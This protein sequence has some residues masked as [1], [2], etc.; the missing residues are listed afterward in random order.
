MDEWFFG[1]AFTTAMFTV[2]FIAVIWI[3]IGREERLRKERD[4]ALAANERIAPMLSNVEEKLVNHIHNLDQF[5]KR[6]E[7]IDAKR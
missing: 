1:W 5:G 6:L 2:A 7:S 4:D 3:A